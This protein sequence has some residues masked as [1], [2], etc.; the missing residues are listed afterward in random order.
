[1]TL[2]QALEVGRSAPP[3][4]LPPAADYPPFDLAPFASVFSTQPPAQGPIPSDYP[5]NPA[6]IDRELTA[7]MPV[8]WG[9]A[10]MENQPSFSTSQ[11]GL[12]GPSQGFPATPSTIPPADWAIGLGTW[13]IA[14]FSACGGTNS[15]DYPQNPADIDRALAARAV[16]PGRK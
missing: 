1:M 12:P 6:D 14:R 13:T 9:R 10:T 11:Y 8:D 4:D 16:S 15:S 5:Q 3:S 7:A 2:G